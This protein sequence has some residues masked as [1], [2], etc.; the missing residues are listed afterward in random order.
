MKILFVGTFVPPDEENEYSGISV[1]G[2]QMQGGFIRGFHENGVNVEVVSVTPRSMVKP[3]NL[4]EIWF[5]NSSKKYYNGIAIHNIAYA[6]IPFLKQ[7][8]IAIHIYRKIKEINNKNLNRERI[9][10][11]VYNS[12]SYFC[13]PVFAISKRNHLETCGIIAD[14]P[15]PGQ[16]KGRLWDIEN[17]FEKKAISKFSK[18]IVLTKQ[19]ALDFAPMVPYTVIEA[20]IE[21]SNFDIT[22][23]EETPDRH[24]IVYTGALN[25]LSG[26]DLLIKV[27]KKFIG[28]KV[29]FD[30]YGSGDFAQNLRD[31]EKMGIPIRYHG[32]V[33]HKEALSAQRKASI[34]VC[35]RLPDNFT[36]RYTFPSKVLEYISREKPVICNHLTGM[37]DEYKQL[38][39]FPHDS[40]VE[41]W[42]MTIEDIL[43][44]Y[45]KYLQKAKRARVYVEQNK[46]WKLCAQKA[47][48]LLC[49][50]ELMEKEYEMHN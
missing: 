3:G 21:V 17:N 1:A 38:V 25:S 6:N 44:N 40:S 28:K 13:S 19:I 45:E 23:V 14:L 32:K 22:D 41:A 33:T 27:S 36:T 24:H 4:S 34:L 48:K 2:N 50:S 7:I 11:C 26:M 43:N 42:E 29:V 5:Q 20:G 30:V 47:L 12:V 8:S 9:V 39:C 18:L 16:R 46:N 15:I 49:G 35:P 10:I 37:P 31:A